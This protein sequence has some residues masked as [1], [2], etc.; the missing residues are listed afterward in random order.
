MTP[1][2]HRDTGLQQ[3]ILPAPGAIRATLLVPENGPVKRSVRPRLTVRS[4]CRLNVLVMNELANQARDKSRL[5][6]TSFLLPP[7][8]HP[9]GLASPVHDS[10]LYNEIDFSGTTDI[11]D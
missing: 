4:L 3:R 7:T 5:A 11:G 9:C 6:R 8:L 1:E 10:I 2:N